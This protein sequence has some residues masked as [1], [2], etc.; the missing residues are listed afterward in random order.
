MGWLTDSKVKIVNGDG[1]VESCTVADFVKAGRILD[2]ANG[3]KD[4]YSVL[5]L[6]LLQYESKEEVKEEVKEDGNVRVSTQDDTKHKRS[7]QWKMG[8][9]S[10]C[11][12]YL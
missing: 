9:V 6:K 11:E 7:N 4:Y 5:A 3:L 1:T 8:S 2:Q 12:L 10:R